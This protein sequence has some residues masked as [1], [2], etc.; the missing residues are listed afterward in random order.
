MTRVC[1]TFVGILD[2]RRL[3]TQSDSQIGDVVPD[4]PDEPAELVAAVYRRSG[5][6]PIVY[7]HAWRSRR[8]VVTFGSLAPVS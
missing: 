2:F 7:P 3:W 4:G 8:A 6:I 1:D 5:M